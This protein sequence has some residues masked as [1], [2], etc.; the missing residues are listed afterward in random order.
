MRVNAFFNINERDDILAS[1]EL[2]SPLWDGSKDAVLTAW[3]LGWERF[4]AQAR[5]PQNTAESAEV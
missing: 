2:T 4:W 3:Q 5:N 1:L